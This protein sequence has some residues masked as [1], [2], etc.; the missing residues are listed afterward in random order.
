MNDTVKS[1]LVGIV[2]LA[3][4]LIAVP[5]VWSVAI[6]MGVFRCLVVILATAGLY[7]FIMRRITK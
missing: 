2:A 5:L 6:R 4:V 3:I 1:I 7:K